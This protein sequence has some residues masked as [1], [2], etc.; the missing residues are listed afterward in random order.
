M[1]R[2]L[3]FARS[4]AMIGDEP[5]FPYERPPLSWGY[6]AGGFSAWKF[7]FKQRVKCDTRRPTWV[8]M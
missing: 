8:K 3:R 6:L 2:Q 1:L 5:E 7:S 4:I